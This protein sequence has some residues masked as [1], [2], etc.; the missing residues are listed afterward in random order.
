MKKVPAEKLLIKKNMEMERA[1]GRVKPGGGGLQSGEVSKVQGQRDCKL[2]KLIFFVISFYFDFH[3]LYLLLCS[4]LFYSFFILPCSK[5]MNQINSNQISLNAGK[6]RKKNFL[7][8]KA[9][10]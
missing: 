9:T 4:F 10:A 1:H 6:N 2:R 5:S 3:L 8:P 7:G